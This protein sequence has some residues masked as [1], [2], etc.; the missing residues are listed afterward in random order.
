MS[1]VHLHR[2]TLLP[3]SPCALASSRHCAPLSSSRRRAVAVV[4]RAAAR[5]LRR[6][7]C[8]GIALL[9]VTPGPK[10]LVDGGGGGC[11]WCP[12]I[13]VAVGVA[14]CT[15]LLV[16]RGT[17]VFGDRRRA[18]GRNARAQRPGG[19]WMG[20]GAGCPVIVVVILGARVAVVLGVSV[21]AS[22]ACYAGF[23]FCR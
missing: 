19:Q 9:C 16:G 15:W 11:Y 5:R 17:A 20:G 10:G 2:I 1:A 14:Q 6:R 23:M 21:W 7:W 12:P 18:L 3:S 8:V 4:L 13:V 22:W